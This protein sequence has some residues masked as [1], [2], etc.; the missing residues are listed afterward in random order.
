MEDHKDRISIPQCRK[1]LGKKFETCTDK[2]IM[3]IR[4]W[5]YKMAKIN[6]KIIN[7][8]GLLNHLELPNQVK[9][10]RIRT[11]NE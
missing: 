9:P 10:A 5:L 8:K 6:V 11:Q 1:V 7:D 4:D 2:E 3:D